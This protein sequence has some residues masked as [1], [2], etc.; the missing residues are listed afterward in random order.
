VALDGAR[1]DVHEVC[2]VGNASTS[3]DEGGEHVYLAWRRM[4]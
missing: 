1:A 4:Q 3:I 2:R